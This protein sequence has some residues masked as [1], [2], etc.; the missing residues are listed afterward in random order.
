MPAVNRCLTC[1]HW[2]PTEKNWGVCTI[3]NAPENLIRVF[4]LVP[5]SAEHAGG[6]GGENYGDLI[7]RRIAR[8]ELHTHA[9]YGCPMHQ[10]TEEIVR[11]LNP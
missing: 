9:E 6:S 7:P 8:P 4:E 2:S 11:D 10:T 5:E 1:G 3:S